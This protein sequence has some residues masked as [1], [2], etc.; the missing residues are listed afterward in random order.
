MSTITAPLGSLA[1]AATDTEPVHTQT[2][3][4][5][6][7]L[8]WNKGGDN[9]LFLVAANGEQINYR[10]STS[11]GALTPDDIDPTGPEVFNPTSAARGAFQVKVRCFHLCEGSAV[12]VEAVIRGRKVPIGTH[13][14]TARHEVWAAGTVNFDRTWDCNKDGTADLTLDN[15]DQLLTDARAVNATDG[16]LRRINEDPCDPWIK[17]QP[18]E[19]GVACFCDDLF[20]NQYDA[21]LSLDSPPGN[22]GRGLD[23][24]TAWLNSALDLDLAPVRNHKNWFIVFKR[25]YSG[26][27]PIAFKDQ[28]LAAVPPASRTD[29]PPSP[30]RKIHF[31][32]TGMGD[33]TALDQAM[34][35]GSR[36]NG[37]T[38]WELYN[39]VASARHKTTCRNWQAPTL[40]F[41]PLG[42]YLEV[43]CPTLPAGLPLPNRYGLSP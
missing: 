42:G 37:I 12:T 17:P 43:T 19:Y 31:N 4:G 38:N 20:G 1:A 8:T 7:T 34:R 24:F 6:V 18:A 40:P 10:R 35:D 36:Y 26:P 16:Q 15:V 22:P 13:T 23:H 25:N 32:L 39:V 41:N 21:A 29:A 14:M 2:G 5:S 3:V 11:M 9:D 28:F 27:Y 33:T 30:F